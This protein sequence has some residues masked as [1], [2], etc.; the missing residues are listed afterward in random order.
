[1]SAINSADFAPAECHYD[2]IIG[3]QQQ[4]ERKREEIYDSILTQRA[5]SSTSRLLPKVRAPL[6]WL[7]D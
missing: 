7:G 5:P 6:L 1:M 4:N 3:N 2:F